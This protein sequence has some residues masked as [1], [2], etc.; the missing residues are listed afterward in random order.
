MRFTILAVVVLCGALLAPGALAGKPHRE[1]VPIG[2]SAELPAGAACP[3]SIAPDGVRIELIAGN[4]AMTTFD[5]GR[6]VWSGTHVDRFTNIATGRSVEIAL[7]G[8]MRDVPQEDG[9]SHASG[10][11]Q[12]GFIFFP[13]DAGPG[14]TSTGRIFLFTGAIRLVFDSWFAVTEF[15]SAGKMQD[16][17]AMIA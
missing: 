9:T 7:E 4:Q 6:T 17:C 3:A 12:L 14:D 8:V 5:N 11:G 1:K 16:V 2:S 13:G 15:E 10:N